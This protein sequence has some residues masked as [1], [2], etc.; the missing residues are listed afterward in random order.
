MKLGKY[1]VPTGN[2]TPGPSRGSPLRYHC[3]TQA[4][5]RPLQTPH[6]PLRT[7]TDLVVVFLVALPAAFRQMLVIHHPEMQLGLD[8]R[9]AQHVRHVQ[10]ARVVHV[11][12]A[13]ENRRVTIEN[14]FVT[15][16]VVAMLVP[17]DLGEER[18]RLTVENVARQRE[19]VAAYVDV[20]FLGGGGGHC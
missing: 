18:V 14:V 16:L 13:A 9:S 19:H 10:V 1:T 12:D 4:P 5:P 11:H 3:A 8:L 7:L 17:S 20:L 15:I 2:Q 6:N